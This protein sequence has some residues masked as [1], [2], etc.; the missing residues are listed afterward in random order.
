MTNNLAYGNV[1]LGVVIA[2]QYGN[3]IMNRT[4]E[5]IQNLDGV[6]NVTKDVGR[7]WKSEQDPG[8]GIHPRA[9]VST[10]LARTTNSRWVTDGSYLTVKNI[11]LGYTIPLT[12]NNYFR[13]IRAYG[14]VQQAFV[15]TKYKGANPEV[16]DSGT[17]ALV[18]GIDYTSYPVPRTISFGVNVN[19]K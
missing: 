14:S 1:D 3:D 6:F 16:N 17:N 12:Q 2:G 15:I 5:Y 10:A 7:R 13:S 19:L 9:V 4:L 8:D 11:T 18:Q